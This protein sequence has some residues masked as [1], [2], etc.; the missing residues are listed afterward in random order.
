MRQAYQ[1]V[2]GLSLRTVSEPMFL[3]DAFFPGKTRNY[4]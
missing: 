2:S 4:F 1:P 3:P